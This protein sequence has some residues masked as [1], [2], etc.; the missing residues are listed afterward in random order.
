MAD[1]VASSALGAPWQAP[2]A[3]LAWGTATSGGLIDRVVAA[4]A[5]VVIGPAVAARASGALVSSSD[6]GEGSE[7]EG[8]SRGYH[9]G[10]N[11]PREHVQAYA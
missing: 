10:T 11:S 9:A 4:L 6:E 3:T 1:S 7:D 5:R 2:I 8:K